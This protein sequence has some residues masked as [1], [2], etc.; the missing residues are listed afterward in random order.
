MLKISFSK[1]IK[2]PAAR[3]WDVLWTD[4]TY[5][6]WTNAFHEGSHAVSDWVEGSEVLFLTPNGS[7]MY[8][9]IAS[10]IPNKFISFQ[11]IGS[12]KDFIKQPFDAETEV[13]SGAFE[14]YSLTEK[15]GFTELSVELDSDN[16]FE[17][18]FKEVFPKALDVV[19]EI[20]ENEHPFIT[21]ETIVQAPIEKVWQKWTIP[22]EIIQW[23][24]AAETWCSP[25]ATNDLKIG[26][27]FNYRM[28]ACDGSEGFDFEGTYTEIE[29]LKKIR[30]TMND[31][32]EA[33][34]DFHKDGN[35]TRIVESFQAEKTN[36]LKLQQFGWQAI[37]NNF[38]KHTEEN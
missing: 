7:G 16:S 14:N 29:P 34:I 31:N 28:E 4:S 5:R 23:N 33:E 19:K 8:S 21:V 10:L 37:L 27:R 2:A 9:K 18:F 1:K 36:T 13:W 25:R 11:H 15:D 20:S 35:N 12:V 30:Y 17:D 26:G 22:E 38:K 24:K 32:R 3:V 6:Q